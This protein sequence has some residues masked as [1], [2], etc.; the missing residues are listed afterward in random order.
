MGEIWHSD[1]AA[2]PNF[3]PISAVSPLWG[4]KSQGRPLS[5][6]HFAMRAMLPVITTTATV[7]ATATVLLL[8]LLLLLLPFFGPLDCVQDYPG[9]TVPE[10]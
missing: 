7:T 6:Q 10:R 9:E 8:L 4:K 5:N 3:T 1:G 2:V